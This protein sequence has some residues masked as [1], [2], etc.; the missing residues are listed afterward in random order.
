MCMLLLVVLVGRPIALAA[1][2]AVAAAAAA[3]A[4]AAAAIALP[5]LALHD[6]PTGMSTVSVW[7]TS[8]PAA[9]GW[10]S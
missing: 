8:W 9:P 1:T 10:P 3:V 2:A 5:V 4:A 6:C 7:R